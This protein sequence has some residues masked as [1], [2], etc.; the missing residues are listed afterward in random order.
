MNQVNSRS[1][2]LIV[3]D[4]RI[5]CMILASMLNSHGISSDMAESG[6]ECVELCRA[7]RY[8]LIL[9]D[10]RMPGCDGIDTFG[11]L[12]DIFREEGYEIPVV[13]H[14][15]DAGRE[16]I[17][18]YK[19]AGF[20][21]VLIKP[22]DPQELARVIM[23]YL[24][25]GDTEKE[26]EDLEQEHVAS[27]IDKLPGDIRAIDGLDVASGID[28][29][30]TAEDYLELLRIFSGS[31]RTKADQIE[32]YFRAGDYERLALKVHSVKSM[33]YLAGALDLSEEAAEL[34][35]AGKEKNAEIISR[36]TP[37]FL[38]HY[39]ELHD[40]LSAVDSLRTAGGEKPSV[41]DRHT[42]AVSPE[43]GAEDK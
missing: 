16:N 17:N 22:I 14:T 38:T 3:D 19:M 35:I 31:I 39:R 8:D 24:P 41:S 12:K 5:N 42:D 18:L 23:T 30:D 37:I 4:M 36:K 13:C 2:V 43:T 26:E 20:A 28:S 29:S 15:T 1:R 9:M 6:E 33:S 40:R 25:E 27:E 34:E 11:M 7:N 32:E 21:D 10:H